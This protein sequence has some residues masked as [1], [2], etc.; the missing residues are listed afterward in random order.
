[1]KIKLIA[2]VTYVYEDL[3]TSFIYVF[4][5]LVLDINYKSK[6]KKYLKKFNLNPFNCQIRGQHKSNMKID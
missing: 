5:P 4:R 6:K 1:M 2:D 3:K